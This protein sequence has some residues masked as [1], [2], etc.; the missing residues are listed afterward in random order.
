MIIGITNQKGGVG[1]TVTS[2]SLANGMFKKNIKTLLVDCD[3]SGN[4]GDTYGIDQS[5]ITYTLYDVLT[6]KTSISSAIQETPYGDIL[7]ADQRLARMDIEFQ[8]A[9]REYVLKEKIAPI[10]H[11]YDHIIMDSSPTLGIMLANILTAADG[12]IIPMVADRY[13]MKGLSDLSDTLQ[14][15]KM[16]TNP[17]LKIYGFLITSFQ[18][19]TIATQ[20]FINSLEEIENLFDTKAFET[21]IHSTT[22]VKQA[23]NARMPITSFK[24][25]STASNDYN[26]LIK[27][28][29]WEEN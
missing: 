25:N 9:G 15:A 22:H 10:V 1:K 19:N 2:T 6:N 14:A 29:L 7:P 27:T 26:E 18:P 16:Y 24:P 28:L 12:V 8:K 5:E 13:S 17:N 23:I 11:E 3:P 21:K 4:A 20:E